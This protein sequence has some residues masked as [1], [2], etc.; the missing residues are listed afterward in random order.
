MIDD[1]ISLK[2][3]FEE[4]KKM[5]WI[6]SKRCGT[7]G[8]GYTFE[9]LIGKEEESF[10]IPDYGTIEIKTRFRNS[11][12]DMTLFNASPDGDYL[13][14]TRKMYEKYGF[15]D[16]KFPNYKVF[17]ANISTLAK[18]AGKENRFKLLVD[19]SKKKIKIIVI[20]R[21]GNLEDTEVSWSF[22]I[23]KEKIERKIK[24]LAIVKADCKFYFGKQHFK[25]YEI[26]FYVLKNF[27]TFISLIEKGIVKTVFAIGF[28]KSG[29]KLG[30][31]N[32]HGVGFDIAEKDIEKLFIKI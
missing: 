32:S 30:Q 19:R 9:T 3:K 14:P 21:I 18:F 27:E 31:M 26:N 4:I 16:K 28:Y 1:L 5:G 2:K 29:P 20:D 23:L 15:P 7:T 24:Y 8:I 10:P 13:F 12:E 6:E 11:K 17:Y 25:Y 22:D